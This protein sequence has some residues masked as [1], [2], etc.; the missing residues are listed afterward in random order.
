MAKHQLDNEYIVNSFLDQNNI[1]PRYE[2]KFRSTI[3][4]N[5]F[6]NGYLAQLG[7]FQE[8]PQ[9]LVNTLYFDTIN[10]KFAID[11]INGTRYRIKP[12][13]RWYDELS[14]RRSSGTKLEYKI[15]DGFLGYK[16]LSETS[17]TNV[18]SAIENRLGVV[19]FPTIET[20]YK[21][22]YLKNIDGIRATI[23]YGISAN[24]FSKS[25]KKKYNLDYEVVE[26]KYG[27]NLDQH[28]REIFF[29]RIN[30]YPLFRLNKSSKYIEGLLSCQLEF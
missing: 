29:K 3:H 21:R 22:V 23:D 18:Q 2:R 28:F 12:R 27:I 16:I 19:G 11:N 4:S 25:S 5:T 7:F 9:R 6:V 26:F 1:I 30:Q 20:N 14:S 10:F 15:K 17:L 8:H 13:L 24:V